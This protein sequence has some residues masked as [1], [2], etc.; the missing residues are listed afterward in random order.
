MNRPSE[1]STN[2]MTS[3]VH[4]NDEHAGRIASTQL[5]V[6]VRNN[7]DDVKSKG[8]KRDDLRAKIDKAVR[9]EL[10]YLD[11]AIEVGKKRKMM[12]RVLK[13]QGGASTTTGET[14]NASQQ[15]TITAKIAL[16]TKLEKA[17]FHKA[18]Q[19]HDRRYRWTKLYEMSQHSDDSKA[20][21]SKCQLP[22]LMSSFYSGG[23][24]LSTT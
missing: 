5:S 11:K 15:Q 23:E 13:E 19:V 7:A 2:T 18:R 6:D 9:V 1:I 14:V 20:T 24:K 3:H 4:W 16:A 8:P 22:P 17:Y 21:P 10:A 12:V